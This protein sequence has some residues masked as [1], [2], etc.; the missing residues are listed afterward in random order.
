M[1]KCRIRFLG[2]WDEYK[3]ELL[4]NGKKIEEASYHTD[5]LLD[6]SITAAVMEAEAFRLQNQVGWFRIGDTYL[7][8]GI[9][10]L[11]IEKLTWD[12]RS[13][14]SWISFCTCTEAEL[15]N[16]KL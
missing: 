3:V 7:S 15:Q 2:D 13:N 14:T 10:K 11:Q 5:D 12:E 9:K 6:A 16:Q 1:R 4:V 8:E